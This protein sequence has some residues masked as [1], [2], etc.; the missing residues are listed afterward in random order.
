MKYDDTYL[1]KA[2]IEQKGR[3]FWLVTIPALPGCTARARTYREAVIKATESIE[4]HL[5]ECSDRG[6]QIQR[7]KL[8]ALREIIVAA[9]PLMNPGFGPDSHNWSVSR[10]RSRSVGMSSTFAD[11]VLPS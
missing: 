3:R 4:H 2:V 8:P 5:E 1:Y 6:E 7:T 10:S 9:R 11:D